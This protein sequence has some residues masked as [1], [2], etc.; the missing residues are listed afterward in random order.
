MHHEF[1]KVFVHVTPGGNE[2][3]VADPAVADHILSRKKD[4]IK[5]ISMLG[6]LFAR[7][8]LAPVFFCVDNQQNQSICSE[9][10]SPQFVVNPKNLSRFLI[11]K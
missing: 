9:S 10:R 11:I 5:P 2:L 6:K 8:P 7:M 1:G 4:F 3:F